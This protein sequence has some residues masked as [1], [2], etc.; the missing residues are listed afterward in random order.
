MDF[1][2]S[3]KN[4]VDGIKQVIEYL[5]EGSRRLLVK[6]PTQVNPDILWSVL[7]DYDNLS[8]FIPNLTSSNLLWRRRNTVGI[9][10]V[11]S[12][13]MLGLKFSAQVKLEIIEYP[14]DGRLDFSMS[15]GD[16]RHFEGFWQIEQ[17]SEITSLVYQLTVKGSI[18]MPIALIEQRLK[19]DISSNL[20]A[21]EKEAQRRSIN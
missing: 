9:K 14:D 16:F 21:I 8:R 7:T 18:G 17:Y 1:P 10:Q 19:N 13:K 5:S 11:G 12:Q 20:R 2:Y 6:L 3:D 4:S 15:S